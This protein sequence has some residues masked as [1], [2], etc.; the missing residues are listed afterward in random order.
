VR[1]ARLF[2]ISRIADVLAEGLGLLGIEAP[3]RV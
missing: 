2:L 1:E 3:E